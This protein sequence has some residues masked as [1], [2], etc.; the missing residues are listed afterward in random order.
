MLSNL[1]RARTAR[2][3]LKLALVGGLGWV[4][5][6]LAAHAEPITRAEA[7]KIGETYVNH[8]WAAVAK[9]LRH[10]KDSVGIEI[11]T[12][13]RG[14]GHG[15]PAAD[16]WVT[17][18]ENT[19]VAYKWGGF[20]TPERFTAGVRAGKAAGDVYTAEKR[21]L[22]GAAVSGDAVG[23]DC[24]GFVSRCWKLPKKHSTSMLAGICQRLDSPAALKPADVMNTAAG[25][26]L[27]FVRWLDEGKKRAL[28]YEAAPYSKTRATECN[29]A[30]LSAAGFVPLRYRRIKD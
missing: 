3:V 26:V 24:S 16:C 13:D 14:S 6:P 10:G 30:E 27:L 11:H 8:R 20:D 1:R 5:V 15:S 9:N 22:G 29:V 12:P 21:R 23:I 17:D 7:L 19:G 25:H 4:V 2:F 18:A 28:F